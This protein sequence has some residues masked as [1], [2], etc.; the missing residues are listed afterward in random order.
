MRNFKIMR[1]QEVTILK[2]SYSLPDDYDIRREF[3]NLGFI[4]EP[5]KIELIIH[6]PLANRIK[7]SI[8]SDDKVSE[9]LD[10]DD[11][12]FKATLNGHQSIV[13]WILGMGTHVEVIQPD[14]LRVEIKQN[15][16]RMLGKY[17]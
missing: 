9:E 14:A 13:K 4:K 12:L 3:P 10:N 7:E 8:Y 15:V 17:M 5:I 16:E 11:I 1:I 6:A 2:E